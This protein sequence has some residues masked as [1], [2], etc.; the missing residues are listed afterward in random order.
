MA[1]KTIKIKSTVFSMVLTSTKDDNNNNNNNNKINP[2][3]VRLYKSMQSMNFSLA[4][5]VFN[6]QVFVVKKTALIDEV[7]FCPKI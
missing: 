3:N 7:W 2:K 4:W 1:T 6:R 5:L